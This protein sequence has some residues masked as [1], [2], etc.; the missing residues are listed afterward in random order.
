MNLREKTVWLI[1]I[2]GNPCAPSSLNPDNSLACLAGNLKRAG[3]RPKIIDYQ[4]VSYLSKFMPPRMGSRI[5]RLVVKYRAVQKISGVMDRYLPAAVSRRVSRLTEQYQARLLKAFDAF[6]ADLQ[7]YHH[8]LIE[9]ISEQLMRRFQQEKPIFI[10]FKLYSGEGNFFAVK[11]ARRLRG[12]INVPLL[13][14]GGLIRIVGAKYYELYPVFDHLIDGEADRA[15]VKYAEMVEGTC[16]ADNVP[17]LI[18]RNGKG[19]VVNPVDRIADLNELA[20]PCYDEDVYPALYEEN[21]KAFVFQIDESR[22]CPNNCSFCI[23]PQISGHRPRLVDPQRI[24]NQIKDL[25]ERFGALAFRFCGSNP[26]GK[27]LVSFA[28]IVKREKL[29]LKYSCYQSVNVVN[30]S[31]IEHLKENGLVGMFFGIETVDQNILTGPFNKPGQDLEKARRVLETCME[32]GVFTTTSWMYPSP[33]STEKTKRD[34][35]DFIISVF[36][37]RSPEIGSVVVVPSIVMPNTEWFAHPESFGFNVPDKTVLVQTY[38]NVN[39]RLFTPRAMLGNL[40]FDL[41]GRDF[42]HLVSETDSLLKELTS[43]GVPLSVTDEWLLM[44]KLSG[45]KANQFMFQSQKA[46]LKGDSAAMR[47]LVGAINRNSRENRF[48]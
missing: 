42:P 13:G 27:F 21:E 4:T 40:G 34:M 22:G 8:G 33:G 20:D 1:N 10:G 19:L 18:Y 43:L 15:I 48:G 2:F 12:R 31:T 41:Q 44:S 14:G 23:H 45:L 30:L 17:G 3:Y 29:E 16:S 28:D 11:I 9:E 5:F 6:N 37:R 46:I 39:I 24:F 25:R 36:G 38:I 7:A 32:R 26:P 47:R 35:V